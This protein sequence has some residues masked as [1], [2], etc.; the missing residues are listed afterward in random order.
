MSTIPN[1]EPQTAIPSS[2]AA[3]I[4]DV[5]QGNPGA[6]VAYV[7][8]YQHAVAEAMRA[9]SEA[10]DAAVLASK[11]RGPDLHVAYKDECGRD[12]TKFVALVQQLAATGGAR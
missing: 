1:P 6:A 4:Y 11:L 10:W 9:A 8:G 5:A 2:F 3:T 7:N 12:P